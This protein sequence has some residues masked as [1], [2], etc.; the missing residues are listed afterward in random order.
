MKYIYKE[1]RGESNFINAIKSIIEADMARQQ[2][3]GIF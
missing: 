3:H 1:S 2:V